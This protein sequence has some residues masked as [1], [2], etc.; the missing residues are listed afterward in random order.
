MLKTVTNVLVGPQPLPRG[1]KGCATRTMYKT[2]DTPTR[3]VSKQAVVQEIEVFKKEKTEIQL[4]KDR[5]PEQQMKLDHCVR[6]LRSCKGTLETY[7]RNDEEI[8]TEKEQKHAKAK[9][10]LGVEKHFAYAH[11]P[12]MHPLPASVSA[13]AAS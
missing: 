12:T 13:R 9:A 3:V 1:A 7:Q 5:D 6:E 4:I 8:E 2:A 10:L 11:V